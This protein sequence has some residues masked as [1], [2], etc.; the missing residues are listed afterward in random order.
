MLAWGLACMMQSVIARVT[1][2]TNPAAGGAGAAQTNRNLS[3]FFA[4]EGV[5]CWVAEACDRDGMTSVVHEAIRRNVDA[6]VAAGGDGTLNAVASAL[7]GTK[8]RFGVIPLGTLN[9]FARDLGIPFDVEP[10]VKVIV[11][12]R[13]ASV[14]VAEVNGR[15]FLNNS[16]LGLYPLL[17]LERR[18]REKTWPN[19]WLA[20]VPALITALRRYPF[21]SVRLDLEGRILIRTTPIVF[22]GNNEYQIEGPGIGTR[23]S[24]NTGRLSLYVTHGPGRWNLVRLALLALFRR[25]RTAREFDALSAPEIWVESPRSYVNVSL[26]GEIER[27]KTPLHYAIRPAALDVIVPE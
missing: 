8:M 11:R 2:I 18:R 17:V 5:D 12:G 23:S 13:T 4:A 3:E 22:V 24:L 1:V 9:H 25:L 15:T 21:L 16:S 19:K 10:A 26:D 20:S 7:T 27:L 14:D 6:V